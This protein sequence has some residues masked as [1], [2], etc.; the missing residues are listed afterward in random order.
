MTIRYLEN[1]KGGGEREGEE[2]ERETHW[3]RKMRRRR[4]G[5]C[6][7]GKRGEGERRG[8]ISD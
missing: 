5:G 1:E 7:K 2:E 3:G 6:E 8:G 4:S